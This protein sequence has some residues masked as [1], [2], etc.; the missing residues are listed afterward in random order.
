[1]Y[2][3]Y[4]QDLFGANFSPYQDT[5][6]QYSRNNSYYNQMMNGY[7]MCCNY[8][9]PTPYGYM[10]NI[11]RNTLTNNL[12][13]L[14]PEIYKIVYPMVKKA[15]NQVTRPIDENLI[16]EMTEDIYNHL[17]AGNIINVNINVD[18]DNTVNK[19]D[20]Q[21]ENRSITRTQTTSNIRTPE[22]SQENRSSE[23]RQFGN[24]VLRDLIRIL[25]LREFISRPRK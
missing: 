9:Q 6:D 14:Y 25:L 5:Y 15:C 13:D 16:D 11:Q 3:D 7:D 18:N 24:P 4:M 12:E 17:E 1:M 8:E 21:R 2:E 20:T 22:K 19:V 23:N 10:P